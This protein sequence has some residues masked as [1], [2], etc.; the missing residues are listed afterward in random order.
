MR[1]FGGKICHYIILWWLYLIREF[2]HS[3]DV[4]NSPKTRP[5]PRFP[6]DT[7]ILRNYVTIVHDN[8]D[9]TWYILVEDL[10]IELTQTSDTWRVLDLA[11]QLPVQFKSAECDRT[12]CWINWLPTLSSGYPFNLVVL[13]CCQTFQQEPLSPPSSAPRLLR[14]LNINTKTLKTLNWKGG[15]SYALFSLF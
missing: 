3:V 5:R 6:P 4:K 10:E 1:G 12:W 14:K 8:R 11:F 2:M 7:Y 15:L 13:P 9:S